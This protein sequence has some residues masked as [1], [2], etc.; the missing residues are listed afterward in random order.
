METAAA[1]G[2][3]GFI[4]VAWVREGA[5]IRCEARRLCSRGGVFLSGTT[6]MDLWVMALCGASDLRTGG[7]D[8]AVAA[9]FLRSGNQR[10]GV[11]ETEAQM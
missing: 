6:W 2:R 8:Q 1:R 7:W 3:E 10:N 9:T 4:R 11:A 5:R